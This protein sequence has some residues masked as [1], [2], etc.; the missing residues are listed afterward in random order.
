MIHEITLF[1]LVLH[2]FMEN[3]VKVIFSALVQD[4][5]SDRMN[6]ILLFSIII[7]S[8]VTLG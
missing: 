8:K 2:G 7:N 3:F 6:K 5:K 1:I 4:K